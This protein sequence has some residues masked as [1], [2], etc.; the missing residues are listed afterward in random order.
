MLSI[1]TL[2]R[3]LTTQ[4]KEAKNLESYRADLFRAYIEH[5]LQRKGAGSKPFSDRQMLQWLAW[6][7]RQML[8]HGQ[9]IHLIDQIQPAWLPN[10]RWLWAYIVISRM[11]SMVAGGLLIGFVAGVC[12]TLLLDIREAPLAQP[13]GWLVLGLSLGL[14][15]GLFLVA[16]DGIRLKR[17]LHVTPKN[18]PSAGKL[19]FNMLSIGLA[20]AWVDGFIFRQFGNTTLAIIGGVAL[21]LTYGL[22]VELR[23]YRRFLTGE[24]QAVETLHWFWRQ[25][26]KGAA[27][28]AAVGLLVGI[29]CGWIVELRPDLSQ[30]WANG[31]IMQWAGRDW[32][33]TMAGLY[34]A[35]TLGLI[36]AVFAGMRGQGSETKIAPQQGLRLSFRH[37]LFSWLGFGLMIGLGGGL[38][39]GLFTG[40]EHSVYVGLTLFIGFGS[41]AAYWYGGLDLIQHYTLRFLLWRAGNSPLN[42][43]SFLDYATQRVFLRKVGGGYVFIHRLFMEYFASLGTED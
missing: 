6:L 11:A 41:L 3:G 34:G 24:I 30:S 1:I 27:I 17:N 14:V 31:L 12:G 9:T 25:A 10:Q 5:M 39:F 8:K 19:A 26:L 22:T 35:C 29:L 2:T 7:A 21:G 36:G 16:I 13:G 40:L 43:I 33:V 28:G 18:L 15:N 4:S 37:A 32:F 20:Y 38:L 42:L 23:S